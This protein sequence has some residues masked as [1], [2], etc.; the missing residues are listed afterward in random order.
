MRERKRHEYHLP[1]W[2][3]KHVHVL[4]TLSPK[5]SAIPLPKLQDH[6][7][8]LNGQYK[9]ATNF[10]A[11]VN[12]LYSNQVFVFFLPQPLAKQPDGDT[13]AGHLL[14][15]ALTHFQNILCQQRFE[16]G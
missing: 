9:D 4:P 5:T 12:L 2:P 7:Y 8:F 15:D 10:S 16:R 13:I 3:K 11:R 14:M 6:E 1:V